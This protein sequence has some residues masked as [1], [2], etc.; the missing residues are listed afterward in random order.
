MYDLFGHRASAFA[1]WAA[2][3]NGRGKRSEQQY[4][5]KYFFHQ[6]RFKV[7]KKLLLQIIAAKIIY[8]R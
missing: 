1:A 5:E 3:G 6:S 8:K 2:A 4:S 7:Q